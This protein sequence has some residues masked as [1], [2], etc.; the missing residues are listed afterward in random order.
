[1]QGRQPRTERE[2]TAIAAP[3]SSHKLIHQ[4]PLKGEEPGPL[5]FPA[6]EVEKGVGCANNC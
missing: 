3:V 2:L 1:M 6:P 5:R 4:H